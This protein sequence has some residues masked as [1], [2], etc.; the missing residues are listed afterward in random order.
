[1]TL[2]TPGSIVSFTPAHGWVALFEAGED[3]WTERVL[4][5]AVV[6]RY[7]GTNEEGLPAGLGLD[8]EWEI[9]TEIEAVVLAEDRYPVTVKHYL[10]DHIDTTRCVGIVRDEGSLP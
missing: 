3:K 2:Y 9:E 7:V 8:P 10:M 4:G 5:W 1:M 6:V